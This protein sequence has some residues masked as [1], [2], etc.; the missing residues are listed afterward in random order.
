MHADE[1]MVLVLDQE[2]DD[3]LIEAVLFRGHGV[4]RVGEH[5]GLE[6]GGKV[7]WVHPVLVGLGGE[8][9]EE[10]EDI[11]QELPIQGW[12]FGDELLVLFDSALHV[13][14]VDELGPLALARGLGGRALQRCP[15]LFIQVYGHDGL[16]EVVE[17]AAKDVG[18][19]VDG[20]SG[21]IEAFAV[22]VGRV[23]KRLELLDALFRAAETKN[24][25][26]TGG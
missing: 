11:E 25:F 10:V 26:N 19:I 16:G 4:A 15:K 5:A 13:E 6:D 14:V 21:P 24:A 18:G 22:L 17:I 23:E 2:Y 1:E 8:D 9:S 12:K 3:A 20:V 7:L